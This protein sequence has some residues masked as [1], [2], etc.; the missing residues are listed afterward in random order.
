[1]QAIILERRVLDGVQSASGLER[2]GDFYY[3]IG[4]DSCDLFRLDAQWNV[5]E[6]I[7]LLDSVSHARGRIAKMHKPDLEALCALEWQGRKE[8]LCFGSG[9]KSPV[10]DVCFRVD[11][12]DPTAPMNTRAVPLGTLYDALRANREIV[13]EHTLNIEA[14][15]AAGDS[16]YLYQRGNIS[17]INAVIGYERR[18]LMDYLDGIRAAPSPGIR[19][20]TLPQI[21]T[22]LA[23]FSAAAGYQAGTLF[24]ATVEDT[25]NEIDDG[26]TLASFIGTIAG[27]DLRWVL[28]VLEQ[29]QVARVKIEGLTL[30][31]A[32][33]DRFELAAVTDNDAGSSEVLL[34]RVQ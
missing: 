26:E 8:L 23:G 25:D 14:A 31:A 4:D 27:N 16:I 22:R 21:G 6:E 32:R 7:H 10:R 17:G 1:M 11:V 9:S 34:V 24:A 15:S 20:F 28:P 5:V 19:S 2:I 29:G 12:T 13:G 3:V 30:L 18:A 33:Q